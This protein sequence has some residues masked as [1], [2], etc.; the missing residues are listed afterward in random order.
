MSLVLTAGPAT[1]P[2]TL[3]L[4][5]SHL[6]VDGSAEDTY[7]AGL[8]ETSRLQIEAALGVALIDQTWQLTI[9]QWPPCGT[10]ELPLHPVASIT[11]VEVKS[12]EGTPVAV[13]PAAFYLDGRA[14]APRVVVSSG[15]LVFPGVPVAGI[16]LTFV[17]GFGSAAGDVPA[18]I[19]HAI[20]LLVAHWF[21]CREASSVD[22]TRIPDEVSA[23]LSPYR[24][25]RI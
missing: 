17:A 21:E 22:R 8:I 19:R 4:A 2:V 12:S 20:L 13:A 9:D 10:L 15:A 7:I 14:L 3:E 6:R 16:T 23:L 18:P 11:S 1:E 25:V 24:R 5:K